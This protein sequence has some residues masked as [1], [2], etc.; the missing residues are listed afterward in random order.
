MKHLRPV[1]IFFVILAIFTPSFSD[2]ATVKKEPHVPKK[3]LKIIDS[4]FGPVFSTKTKSYALLTADDVAPHAGKNM[5]EPRPIASLTKL[6]TAMVALDLGFDFEG[7]TTYNPARHYAYRNYMNF[8]KGEVIKNEDLWYAMLV[9]SMNVPARMIVDSLGQSDEQFVAEM[10][11]KAMLLGLGSTHFE[12]V[13]GLSEKNVSNAYEVGLLFTYALRHPA[14]ARALSI[15]SYEFDEVK[16]KDKRVHHSFNH[17]DVLRR[18]NVPFEIVAS[19]TG[20]TYE[21]GP[22]IVSYIVSDSVEYIVVTLG[23][24]NYRERHRELVTMM[25]WWGKA[26]QIAAR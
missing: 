25:T 3:T 18:K 20:Y 26:T 17:T 5:L 6:M 4:Y 10:N 9:G 22:C 11:H 8:Q 1:F 16:S 12:D 13:H 24:N 23:E 15:D 14:I 21:A 7:A 19:K 2:A